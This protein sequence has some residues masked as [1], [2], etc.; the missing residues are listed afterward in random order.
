MI[1]QL[2]L[3]VELPPQITLADFI[4]G[5]NRQLLD[6]LV[7]IAAGRNDETTFIAGAAD[8]GKT[9]LL[10]GLC[11]QAEQQGRSCSYL[12]LQDLAQLSP[13]LLDG[14]E[15][16]DIIAVDGV[17]HI[18]GNTAW[19]EALFVLF[20][21]ARAGQRNLVFSA[22]RGPAQ[23]PLKLPDLR[24]RLSWGSTYRLQP[25][26]DEGLMELLQS[27]AQ[28]RGLQLKFSVARWLLT[29]CSRNPGTLLALMERLDRKALAEKRHNLSLPFVQ[30][31]L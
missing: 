11:C 29:H 14:L 7:R 18:A 15:T 4:P 2:P 22:D 28:K 19:E 17:Q 5:E 13:E 3:A 25:L 16:M 12:P 27:Q 1:Q 10:M 26:D 9:H 21:L 6:Q 30:S 8:S 23:L 20:N 31:C 24:S